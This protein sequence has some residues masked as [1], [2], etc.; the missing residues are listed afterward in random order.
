MKAC[1]TDIFSHFVSKHSGIVLD[2]L[3]FQTLA[4]FHHR[5]NDV[6]L[7]AF[8]HLLFHK[9]VRRFPVACIYNAIFDG[10]AVFWNLVDHG[11]VKVAVQYDGKCP[12][13]GSRTHDKDMRHT[14]FPGKSFPLFYTE[15]VLLVRHDY[16]EIMIGYFILDQSMGTD[17]DRNITG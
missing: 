3:C 2:I 15:T 4:F 1:D 14:S 8:S 7:P 13:D 10:K 5:T 6:T 17:D 12:R 9:T 11:N 16:G